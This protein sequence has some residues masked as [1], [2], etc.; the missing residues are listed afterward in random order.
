MLCL[1][2]LSYPTAL[3]SFPLLCI[4]LFIILGKKIKPVL[5]FALTSAASGIAYLLFLLLRKGP[6]S[7]FETISLIFAGDVHGAGGFGD[8]S[9]SFY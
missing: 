8:G 4:A 9:F 2:I 1:E 3:I 7:L 6:V 5:V